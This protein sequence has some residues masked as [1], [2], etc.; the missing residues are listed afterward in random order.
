MKITP[1]KPDFVRMF[2]S[3]CVPVQEHKSLRKGCD[4][5]MM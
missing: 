5:Q 1:G 4:I 2:L 3:F